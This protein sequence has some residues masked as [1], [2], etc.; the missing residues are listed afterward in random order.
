[1][2][3]AILGY[4][5]VGGGV[6]ELL[7]DGSLDIRVK[8]VLDIR[9]LEAL[10]G[11]L[12]DNIADILSDPAIDC[13]V[14]TIGG[15][16][17]ALSY[18]TSALRSG[19]HVVTSNKELI[20]HALAPLAEGAAMHGVQMRFS[21]SVGGGV[22]WIDNIARQKR[23]DTI[24]ALNGIVNGTTNYILDAMAGGAT[25]AEALSQ[26]QQKGY[27]ESDPS[28]DLNGIDA[29]RKCAISAAF[30]FNGIIEPQM[31]P[32]LGIANIRKEDID[33]FRARGFT[34]KLMMYAARTDAGASAYVEPSLLPQ[35]AL[36]AHTPTNHNCISMY[37]KNVGH[38]AFYGEGAGRY[39]TAQN[40]VQDLLGIQMRA[41]FPARAIMPMDVDNEAVAHPYY[42]RTTQTDAVAAHKAED[43]GAAILTTPLS[44]QKAHALAKELLAADPEAF[45]AGVPEA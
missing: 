12:T 25:F 14:E 4:G 17:P 37:G 36:A 27:A 9:P 22:P 42:I 2:N 34:C 20:S 7:K 35:T 24:Y 10:Q 13:V 16:H 26:A 33:A 11:L 29:Q 5:T 6:Y 1:M 30:A 41:S 28:A 23:S 18:V 39:P 31:V 8:R 21:A 15:M 44:V 43:W 32:A 45:L 3:I 40:I 38:L 19:K